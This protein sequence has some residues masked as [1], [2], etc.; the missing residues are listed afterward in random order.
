M[1][2]NIKKQFRRLH[3][4]YIVILGS[5]SLAALISVII[6]FKM[7]AFAIFDLQT[8]N[9]LKAVVIM[10]LLVGIPVSHIFYFKKIKH[11]NR[12]LTLSKKIAMFQ[13]AFVVRIALLEGI[14]LLA[15]MAYLVAADK[16]FL[17]MFAVVFVLFIIH[18]PTKQRIISD[19]ELDDEE[20]EL[21]AEQVK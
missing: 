13:L 4:I 8:L 14:G 21:L 15:M 18:A 12:S 1:N 11:I 2:L 17:Y 6:V 5:M 20:S 9:V 7:G 3:S 16:S 10:A 19:L